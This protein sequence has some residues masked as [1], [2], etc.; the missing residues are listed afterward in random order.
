M[1]IK[2]L[3][4]IQFFSL[5]PFNSLVGLVPS[6]NYSSF[7]LIHKTWLVLLIGIKANFITMIEIQSLFP[8]NEKIN[9]QPLAIG[10]HDQEFCNVHK[11]SN[12]VTSILQTLLETVQGLTEV[13][14]GWQQ[15]T[16][17]P[18]RTSS[19]MVTVHQESPLIAIS[20]VVR[21]EF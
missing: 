17:S 1:L 20:K 13:G 6:K 2:I 14:N 11:K 18:P 19:L 4:S 12:V 7:S 5:L 21:L 10:Q 15:R 3:L 8:L 16:A 9:T